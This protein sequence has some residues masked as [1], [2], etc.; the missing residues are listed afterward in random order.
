MPAPGS[1]A[2][3]LPARR[4]GGDG[5]GLR[6]VAHP[7]G[8]GRPGDPGRRPDARQRGRC[9]AAGPALRGRRKRWRRAGEGHQGPGE[10]RALHARSRTW[11]PVTARVSRAC[12]T[13][14]GISARMAG[15]SSPRPSWRRST[16]CAQ[17]YERY[18]ADPVFLAELEADLKDYV[19]RPSPIYHAE[20]LSRKTGWSADLPQA[21]GPQPHRRAQGEQH[22]RPGA[23]GAAHGQDP[24][25][26]RDGRGAARRGDGH[27][28]GAPGPR[29]RRLHGRGGHR[30]AGGE[31]LPHAPAGR[32]RSCRSGR[33]R[34]PSR[35]R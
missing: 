18:R 1:A 17:A 5:R 15:C 2:R 14:A 21:R 11:Q 8:A 28:G 26:R 35:T 27:G 32:R 30:A 13:G 4:A 25:H 19:G 22:R 24:D 33:A 10:D 9:G 16:S 6:L 3:R 31:R 7:A 34:A 12:P 29:V 23:A 20:R